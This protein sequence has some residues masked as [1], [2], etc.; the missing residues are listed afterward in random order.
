MEDLSIINFK[1]MN[2]IIPISFVASPITFQATLPA[3]ANDIPENSVCLFNNSSTA[4][5]IGLPNTEI[6]LQG[7]KVR[8]LLLTAAH[9]VADVFTGE[10]KNSSG[11]PVNFAPNRYSQLPLRSFNLCHG[12]N[13]PCLSSYSESTSQSYCVSSDLGLAIIVDSNPLPFLNKIII[14]DEVLSQNDE[15]LLIGHPQESETSLMYPAIASVLD[16]IE[17]NE[18]AD[19]IKKAFCNFEGLIKSEGLVSEISDEL[20]GVKCSATYGMSGGPAFAK[21]ID[22]GGNEKKKLMGVFVGGPP[23]H[24]QH[25]LIQTLREIFQYRQKSLALDSLNRI[26]CD[27]MN[28]EIKKYFI[29]L[30]N[31]IAQSFT[32]FL[33]DEVLC[34]IKANGVTAI[35]QIIKDS[36]ELREKKPEFFFNSVVPKTHPYF[37][38]IKKAISNFEST[39][40]G[41]DFSSLSDLCSFLMS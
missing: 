35:N 20:I 7:I 4:F 18:I 28:S 16:L 36:Q 24:G 31:D 23:L 21:Y 30:L 13:H 39:S 8:A 22:N 32:E 25:L 5:V 14:D 40:I 2:I 38:V 15:C 6:L 1:S 12:M 9:C 29:R 10:L 37:Q 41:Q 11:F 19:S 17:K 27:P 26:I 33:S 34:Y 3:S